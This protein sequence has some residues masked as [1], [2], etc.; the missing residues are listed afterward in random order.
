MRVLHLFEHAVLRPTDYARRALALLDGLRS[1]GVQTVQLAAPATGAAGAA[2]VAE[3]VP[4]GWQFYRTAAPTSLPP[5]LRIGAGGIL[6]A[7][8]LHDVTRLTRPQLIHVHAGSRHALAAWPAARLAR[9]PLL[10]E[11]DRRA[12]GAALP[13]LDRLALRGA[14]A[15]V[16]ATPDVRAFLRA[17]G[18]RARRI[19]VLPSAADLPGACVAVPAPRGLDGAPLLA[20]AGPLE[21]ADGIDLLLEALA[22]LR[23]RRPALRLVVAGAGMRLDELEQSAAALGLR[24]HVVFTGELTGRRIADLL[25]RA[26][27][28]V[29]PAMPGSRTAGLAPPRQLLNAMAQGCTV[30]ASDIACHAELL[31]N[32]HNGMLFRAGSR[33]A[34]CGALARL[35]DDP[36]RLR[37]LG[38]AAADT[39]AARHSWPV[40]AARYRKLYETILH[41]HGRHA[42]MPASRQRR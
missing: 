26:D 23:R 27:V 15:L 36:L 32:G 19:A 21:L 34:L 12:A 20:Y 29:F 9:L 17:G 30:V 33:T 8:R 37:P 6:L 41:D 38:R 39:I 2:V 1:Q 16:A 31:V 25:P 14:D 10:V 42:G 22:L 24:G 28:T 35:L 4:A 3:S 11:A 5:C 13:L 7:Q 40:A 18:I